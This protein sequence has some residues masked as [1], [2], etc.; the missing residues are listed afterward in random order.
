MMCLGR[1]DR[2]VRGSTG[3]PEQTL[4]ERPFRTK[5]MQAAREEI[6]A[7]AQRALTYLGR[8]TESIT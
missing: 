2:V 1:R 7:A 6:A 8:R 5:Q 4:M 3:V